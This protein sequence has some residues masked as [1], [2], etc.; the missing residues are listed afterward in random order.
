MSLL[1][2]SYFEGVGYMFEEVNIHQCKICGKSYKTKGSLATHTSLTH[3]KNEYNGQP[4]TCLS[5]GKYFGSKNALNIHRS[6]YH[7]KVDQ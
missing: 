3:G 4:F 5:C 2:F 1:E 7:N 6:R